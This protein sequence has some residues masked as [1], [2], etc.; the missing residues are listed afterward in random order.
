LSALIN[1]DSLGPAIGS[2]LSNSGLRPFSSNL[3]G[4]M[5]HRG[6]YKGNLLFVMFDIPA[7][8]RT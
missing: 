6:E 5:A 3:L 4:K 1:T 2:D 8:S 7:S